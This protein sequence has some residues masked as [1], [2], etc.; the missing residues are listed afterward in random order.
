VLSQEEPR[1]G[2]VNFDTYRIKFLPHY[3]SRRGLAIACRP[4]IT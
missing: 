1:D 4:P 3:G 2:A